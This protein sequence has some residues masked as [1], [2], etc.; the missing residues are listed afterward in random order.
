MPDA[1]GTDGALATASV[2]L[3]EDSDDDALF[4]RKDL[5][6]GIEYA[7][8]DDIEVTRVASLA[9]AVEACEAESF[10][11][12]FLDLGLPD[13]NGIETV[14]RFTAHEF[15]VPVVVLTGL[16]DRGM[17]L[18]AIREGAQDYLVKGD[19]TP[20]SVVRSMRHGIE[21]K[22]NERQLRRQRDQMEFFNSILQ[23][24]LLNGME[25]IRGYARMLET[26]LEGEHREQAA[27]VVDWSDNIVELTGKVRDVLDTLTSGESADLRPV[28][29]GGLLPD[30]ASE[31]EALREGATVT[32]DCPDDVAV[33]ADELFEDVL[34]N[35]MT[36][37]VVHTR[38]DPVTVAVSVE[39]DGDSV[40]I[41]VADDGPG[42][43]DEA[44]EV[45][46]DRG[47]KGEGSGGSGFGLYF[48]ASM[49]DTYGGTI[50]VEDAD[51]GG[52]RFVMELP[53]AA[54]RRG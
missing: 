44:K 23:H 28:F 2:L 49:L 20:E 21:R 52:A 13:S 1:S 43:P 50:H 39:R 4:I 31:T 53:R 41:V 17:A 34:R 47:E 54:R 14:S 37:A 48:V 25:V 16:R 46:F 38:P 12:V 30:L 42:V 8:V 3:V 6:A 33:L 18:E 27:T 51:G 35:L 36:N 11:A 10:D 7:F 26:D 29:L 45:I 22:K 32:V 9:A 24:D 15:D 5:E 40:R 19:T